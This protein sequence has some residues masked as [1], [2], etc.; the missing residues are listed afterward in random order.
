MWSDRQNVRGHEEMERERE[1]DRKIDREKYTSVY[2]CDE[3][4]GVGLRG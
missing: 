4:D 1:S 2:S 3:M